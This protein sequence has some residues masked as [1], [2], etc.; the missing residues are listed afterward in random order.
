[1]VGAVSRGVQRAI[2]TYWQVS[3]GNLHRAGDDELRH[4]I[5]HLAGVALG[6]AR[7][8]RAG[9]VHVGSGG[10]PGEVHTLAG[11][12]QVADLLDLVEVIAL[13]KALEQRAVLAGGRAQ[14]VDDGER[15]LALL[16]VD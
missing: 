12:D 1:M 13:E 8:G 11:E 16:N 6:Q 15:E 3:F 7:D 5:E 14:E 10:V 9:A 2:P 4:R